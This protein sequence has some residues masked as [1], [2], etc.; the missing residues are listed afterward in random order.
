MA[1]SAKKICT[2]LFK[3]A[4]EIC[5]SSFSFC[6]KFF[7]YAFTL[8]LKGDPRTM[9]YENELLL[10]FFTAV[11][12]AVRTYFLFDMNFSHWCHKHHSKVYECF[13]WFYFVYEWQKV[14]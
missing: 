7:V 2:A 10:C 8:H 3:T 14:P 12:K 1:Q 11:E 4:I 13:T 9:Y 5:G 6:F